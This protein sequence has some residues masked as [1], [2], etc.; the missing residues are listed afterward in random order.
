MINNQVVPIKYSYEDIE[1]IAFNGFI[2]TIPQETLDMISSIAVKVGSPAYIK[3]PVFQKREQ[4][5]QSTIDTVPVRRRRAKEIMLGN[6]DWD[7]PVQTQSTS[8]VLVQKEGIDA[9]I[10]Q[11]RVCLNKLSE[12]TYNDNLLQIKNILTTCINE[13]ATDEELYKVGNVIFEIASNNKF[14]SKL[15]ANVYTDLMKSFHQLTDI[16]DKNYESYLLLF[17]NIE[18]IDP[19]VDYNQFCINNV[20]NEKRKAV[21]AFFVNLSL[22]GIIPP[23]HIMNILKELFESVLTLMIQPNKTNEVCEL[24]ENIAILYNA[25]VLKLSDTLETNLNHNGVEKTFAQVITQL[26]TTRMKTYPSLSSKSIFKCMDL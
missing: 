1:A 18:Y 9:H 6:T 11:I 8:S 14:F 10:N 21:S 5:K 25:Q 20:S 23:Q 22:N 13:N 12:I 19:D 7:S 3:T 24:I 16:F 17:K 2:C 15:Y 4:V 26:S